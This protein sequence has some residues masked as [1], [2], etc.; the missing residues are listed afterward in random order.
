LI[1][2]NGVYSVLVS[3]DK[4]KI[5]RKKAMMNIGHRPT[6]DGNNQT[7]EVNLFNFD[8]NIYDETLTITLKKYLRSEEKF[9]GLDK[10]KV[11]LEKDK[12]AALDSLKDVGE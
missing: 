10:L 2:C 8:Q 5:N 12:L 6:V 7:I 3:N 4:L 9:S 1:P 11:Q